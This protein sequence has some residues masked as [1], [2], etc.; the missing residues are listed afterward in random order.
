MADSKLSY[1]SENIPRFY[2]KTNDEIQSILEG[3]NAKNTNRATKSIMRT[4]H[5]YLHEKGHP[6]IDELDMSE[7]PAIL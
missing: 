6:I 7:L 2:S 1:E 3:R 4:F 5:D